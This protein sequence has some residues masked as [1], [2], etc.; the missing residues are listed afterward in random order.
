[1]IC[2]GRRHE[3][4]FLDA[5]EAAGGLPRPDAD[6]LRACV[7]MR[8]VGSLTHQASAYARRQVAS[9]DYARQWIR[10]LVDALAEE[11]GEG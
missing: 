10:R 4:A 3:E 11:L 1:M 8:L 6:L 9:P 2:P 7:L 5:Y